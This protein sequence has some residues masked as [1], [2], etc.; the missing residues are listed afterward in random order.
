MKISKKTIVIVIV[1]LVAAWLLWKRI[2]E[3]KNTIANAVS[4]IDKYSVDDVISAA[5]I[6]G[7]KADKLRSEVNYLNST[8]T[9]R[10]QIEDK[11]LEK[12]RTYEQQVVITALYSFHY[13][14]EDASWK[15]S[16]SQF[17]KYWMAID[18]M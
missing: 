6:T 11:A 8:S 5:G 12:G 16:K 17:E 14:K 1:V 13:K 3:N 10:S 4:G 2:K 15:I 7:T 18:A 9:W